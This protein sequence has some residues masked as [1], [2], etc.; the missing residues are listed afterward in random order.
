VE[1]EWKAFEL[2]PGIPPEGQPVPWP[3]EL[4]AERGENFRRLADEAGLPHGERTHWFDSEP[5][6]E[7]CEWAREHG[8]EEAFRHK[9]YDAYF[10]KNINIGSPD[11]LAEIAESLGLDSQD[12]RAALADGRYRESVQ[13]QF[14]E[15]RQVGVTG[16]PTFMA[17]GYA[18]VGAQP[19]SMFER[20]MEVVEQP[21]HADAGAG[22]SS[23]A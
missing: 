15:A 2:H 4:R 13:R 14:A 22:G 6:H 16:V 8:T 12:L 18:I 3:P 7:A 17:G 21:R 5:A 19:Y 11:V 10:V 9:I 20:L 1:V 23:P